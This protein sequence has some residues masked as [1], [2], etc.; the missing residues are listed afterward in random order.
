MIS[1]LYGNQHLK[2]QIPHSSRCRHRSKKLA[3][4]RLADI[5]IVRTASKTLF[6]LVI[7]EVCD[8]QFIS[9]GVLGN[10]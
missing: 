9:Q 6:F 10:F 2:T 5:A 4:L 7:K 1:V 8:K 3:V